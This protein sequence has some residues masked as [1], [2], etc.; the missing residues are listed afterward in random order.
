[1]SAQ[2]RRWVLSGGLASGKSQVR[3]FLDAHGV[4]TIDADVIGH[5]VLESDG[6][7]FSEVERRWPQVVQAGEVIRSSL[8]AV[9]FGDPA[10]LAALEAITHP[11]IFGRI[12]A[13][14]EEVD[15]LVVVEVPVLSHSLGAD[16]RR[17]VVDCRDQIRLARAIERGMSP[18]DARARIAAQPTRG[19]WLAAADAVIPNH[20]ALNQLEQAVGRLCSELAD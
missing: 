5:E 11:H 6:P 8:A 10:E 14:V 20:G 19:E 1:V 3:R 4:H 17:I 15:G 2:Q 9:V 13:Q 12:T 7:A 18:D 16:W